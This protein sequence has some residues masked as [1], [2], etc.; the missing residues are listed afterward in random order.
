MLGETVIVSNHSLHLQMGES[1]AMLGTALLPNNGR[2]SKQEKDA[3]G[4]P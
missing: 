3:K 1:K 4:V 2:P